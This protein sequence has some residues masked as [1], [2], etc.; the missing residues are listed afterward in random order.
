MKYS[1]STNKRE[2]NSDEFRFWE[3]DNKDM[4]SDVCPV[5]SADQMNKKSLS[6]RITH[7]RAQRH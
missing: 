7:Q 4:T 5:I 6:N 1:G 2:K 3:N